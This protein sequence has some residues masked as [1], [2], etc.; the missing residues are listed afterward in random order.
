M[1]GEK[2]VLL[3]EDDKV[4][5]MAFRRFADEEGN[6]PY[7]YS[8]AGSVLE[9]G[10]VLDSEKFDVVLIDYLLGDGT[11]FDLFEKAKG[12]PIVLVTGVGDEEVA[13][14]A[15]KAGAYDYLVKGST[16]L[17]ILPIVVGKAIEL[18]RVKEELNKYHKELEVLVE[19]RTM[20]LEEEIA[21]HRSTEVLLKKQTEELKR[22][23]ADLEQFVYVASHDLKG[24][25]RM[26]GSYVG[27]LAKRYEGRLDSDAEEYIKFAVD[28][29]VRMKKL[30]D[31]LLLYSRLATQNKKLEFV[32]CNDVFDQIVHDLKT[33]IEERNVVITSDVLPT[34]KGNPIR[35][36]QLLEN[37]ISNAIKFCDVQ[38]KIEVKVEEEKESW[39]FSVTDNGIGIDSEF[40]KQIFTIFQRLNGEEYMGTGIGL[41]VCKRIVEQHGGRIWVESEVR[42][43]SSFYFTIPFYAQSTP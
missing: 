26:V 23:N 11:A 39:L 22:S 7:D 10:K 4:D 15:M 12:T 42:K 13:V 33:T 28:G 5:Q 20:E 29:T 8:I 17:E 27:L 19:E 32:N 25:L 41:S 1:R 37:L 6:L 43:G 16:Y 18:K 35:L 31:D 3:V 2:K 40:S 36:Y 21:E 24:P 38:P 9:A 14:K 30:I 34:V